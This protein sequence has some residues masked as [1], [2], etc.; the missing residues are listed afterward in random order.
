MGNTV[1]Y[2]TEKNRNA[3]ATSRTERRHISPSQR[4]KAT[5]EVRDLIADALA[6]SPDPGDHPL[7][8][9]AFFA[10]CI[11]HGAVREL[12]EEVQQAGEVGRVHE[13]ALD[14]LGRAADGLESAPQARREHHELAGQLRDGGHGAD[15]TQRLGHG[16]AG[17]LNCEFID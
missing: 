5:D 15:Y 2:I 14:F 17:D 3:F 11:F 10:L 4:S 1:V 6:L 7:S 16:L 9:A 8:S 13:E 12:G